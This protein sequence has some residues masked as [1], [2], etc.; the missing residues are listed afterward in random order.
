MIRYDD[1][2]KTHKYIYYKIKDN[3]YKFIPNEKAD[4]G[5]YNKIDKNRRVKE[6]K[7]IQIDTMYNGMRIPE[8]RKDKMKRYIKYYE[9]DYPETEPEWVE[10]F[11]QLA[12]YIKNNIG[13]KEPEYT[14][15]EQALIDSYQM[16]KE[17]TYGYDNNRYY[18]CEECG[19]L[20][21]RGT[22]ELHCCYC[23]IPVPRTKEDYLVNGGE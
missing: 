13:Y 18:I 7:N 17:V 12:Y 15:E 11:H 2:N 6:A 14:P 5:Y 9:L 4:S 22:E 1:P 23:D 3:Y 10:V 19:E 16:D 20:I 8:D 21:N